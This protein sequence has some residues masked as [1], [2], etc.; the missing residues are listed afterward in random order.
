MEKRK[1]DLSKYTDMNKETVVRGVDNTE[2]TVCNH[3]PFITKE[4]MVHDLLTYTIGLHEDS[5]AYTSADI[6]KMRLYMIAKYYTDID[7]EDV[8]P[9]A[10]ADFLINNELINEIKQYINDDMD[11]VVG[12]YWT[13]LDAFMTTYEDDH[14]LKKMIKTSFGFLFNGEDITETLAKTE[15]AKDTIYGAITALREKEKEKEEKV[16]NGTLTI[17]GN[18]INFAKKQN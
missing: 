9:V 15:A 10:V 3:I 14:S 7:T 5:C 12:M 4:E 18:V 6:E 13:M 11:Y 17:G 2:V 16:D 8:D 1:Y